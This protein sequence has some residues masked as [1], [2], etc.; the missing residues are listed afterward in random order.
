MYS[1]NIK[2]REIAER[3]DAEFTQL[4]IHVQQEDKP[5]RV[6]YN[7][8]ILVDDPDSLVKHLKALNIEAKRGFPGAVT[9]QPAMQPWVNDPDD[10][11]VANRIAN[12]AVAL[13]IYPEL[14]EEQIALVID[15]VSSFFRGKQ[16]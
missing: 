14:T 12:E 2:R 11:P 7:Y 13:P 6:P 16:Q 15:G 9:Q 8:V 5:E 10:Y 1:E 3:Y 4:N